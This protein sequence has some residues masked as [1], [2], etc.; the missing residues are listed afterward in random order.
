M[1]VIWVLHKMAHSQDT[2]YPTVGIA[3]S[4]DTL[5]G[6]QYVDNFQGQVVEVNVVL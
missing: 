3:K 1:T 5:T 2:P 4:G 6:L